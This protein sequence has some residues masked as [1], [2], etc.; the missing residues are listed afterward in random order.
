MHIKKIRKKYV[1]KKSFC[2]YINILTQNVP[3]TKCVHC[4]M[5]IQYRSQQNITPN[6]EHSY[7]KPYLFKYITVR[8]VIIG[9]IIDF[10]VQ[11]AT[12]KQ[13]SKIQVVP[14]LGKN[15]TKTQKHKKNIWTKLFS[16]LQRIFCGFLGISSIKQILYL[17]WDFFLLVSDQNCSLFLLKCQKA[18]EDR[19]VGTEPSPTICVHRCRDGSHVH[20]LVGS[21]LHH[22]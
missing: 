2:I 20:L 15:V 9:K 4:T 3:K 22:S 14:L 21:W 10:L 12:S 16:G 13:F 7:F 11:H 5:Y 18:T 17:L 1:I 6:T 8:N 19:Q